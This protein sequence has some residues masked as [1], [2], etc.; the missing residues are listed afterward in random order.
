MR[1]DASTYHNV[2]RLI[3]SHMSEYYLTQI[4]VDLA[5]YGMFVECS[6]DSVFCRI[7]SY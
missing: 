5:W 1:P 7:I 6:G 2:E 3:A 4:I